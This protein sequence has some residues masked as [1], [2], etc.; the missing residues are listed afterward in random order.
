MNY[1]KH[2]LDLA[3]SYPRRRY[4]AKQMENARAL[5]WV[6]L[7]I[8]LAEIAL[9][10]QLDRFLGTGRGENAN[11]FRALGAREIMQGVDILT[12][13]DPTPGIYARVAG[14]VLDGTL[15]SAAAMKTKNPGGVL[16]AFLLVAPVVVADCIMAKRLSDA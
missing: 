7:A 2:V 11:M 12:H 10:K 4:R 15:L 6:S 9:P 5:G 8:G 13:D 1:A 14:D 16:A 3:R